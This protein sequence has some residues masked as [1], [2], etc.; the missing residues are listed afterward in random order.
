MQQWTNSGKLKYL[1]CGY[2]LLPLKL[3]DSRSFYRK[4]R[5]VITPAESP[6]WDIPIGFVLER[7]LDLIPADRRASI[8]NCSRQH[9]SLIL[10][11]LAYVYHNIG[12]RRIKECLFS[13]DV[14]LL[15]LV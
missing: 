14:T 3:S 4:C 2:V 10:I 9:G 1:R 12:E 7:S 15:Q 5:R 6:K 11:V 13:I 8:Y